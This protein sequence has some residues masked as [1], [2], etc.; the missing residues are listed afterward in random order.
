MTNSKKETVHGY[1]IRENRQD[2]KSN[3][4]NS[5]E[6]RK[7]Y[8]DSAGTDSTSDIDLS[9]ILGKDGHHTDN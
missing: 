6:N 7:L 4:Y 9:L 3:S 2:W 1:G 5:S 8:F